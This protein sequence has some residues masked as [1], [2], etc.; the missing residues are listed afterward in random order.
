MRS[1]IAIL[2]ALALALSPQTALAKR[3]AAAKYDFRVGHPCPAT[4]KTRGPCQGYVIDH[5]KPLACGGADQP[6][7]MQWQTIAAGKAKDKWERRGGVC[8]RQLDLAHFD[9]LIWPTPRDIGSS[10][11]NICGAYGNG[12][13][14]GEVRNIVALA[15]RRPNA[16]VLSAAPNKAIGLF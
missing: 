3:S 8:F 16:T 7:N 13:R 2:C 9:A 5:V 14:Y 6:A 12:L 4:G 1:T 10:T 15:F 11:A